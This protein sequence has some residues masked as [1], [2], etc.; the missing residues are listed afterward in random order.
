MKGRGRVPKKAEGNS[1]DRHH[2]EGDE[3][4][5]A[6]RW[7]QGD[8]GER[9]GVNIA[10]NN[11]DQERGAQRKAGGNEGAGE[12]NCNGEQWGEHGQSCES[13]RWWAGS[14]GGASSPSLMAVK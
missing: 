10:K 6:Q 11:G 9:R 5:A 2:V 7:R 12:V 4:K 3:C 8:R 1:E 13:C 14:V